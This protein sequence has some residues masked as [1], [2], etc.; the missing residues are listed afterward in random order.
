MSLLTHSPYEVREQSYLYD[1]HRATDTTHVT[2][3]SSALAPN[4]RWNWR[5]LSARQCNARV[6]P[7]LD[8]THDKYSTLR[9]CFLTPCDRAHVRECMPSEL[10]SAVQFF[11]LTHFR[12]TCLLTAVKYLAA[13]AD[14]QLISERQCKMVKTLH[15]F[16]VHP[17]YSTNC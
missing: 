14:I 7:A 1:V 10:Q 9:K 11:V 17:R 12:L 15:H 4:V 13:K 5:A 6:S 2:Q 8:Y 3:R 16:F